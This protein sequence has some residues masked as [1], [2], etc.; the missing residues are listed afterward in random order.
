MNFKKLKDRYNKL[1]A[2]TR[3]LIELAFFVLEYGIISNIITAALVGNY[4]TILNVIAYG[5]VW[6]LIMYQ[7]ANVRKAIRIKEED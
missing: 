5:L 3:H 2:Q 7:T 4:I 1:G 6:Y